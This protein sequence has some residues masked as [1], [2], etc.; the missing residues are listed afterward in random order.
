MDV[1]ELKNSVEAKMATI[2]LPGEALVEARGKRVSV[3]FRFADGTVS[4]LRHGT[5]NVGKLVLADFANKS[6][7]IFVRY[8]N[9]PEGIAND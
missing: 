4:G 1:V 8:S 6:V 9:L 3:G 7:Q 2:G 5:K